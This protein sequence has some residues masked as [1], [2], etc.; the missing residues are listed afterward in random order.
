MVHYVTELMPTV[1]VNSGD[2]SVGLLERDRT[3]GFIRYEEIDV[4]VLDMLESHTLNGS[5]IILELLSSTGR[6]ISSV[7]E[8]NFVAI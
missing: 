2:R 3:G 7:W 5:L 8:K 1:A 6:L 4:A